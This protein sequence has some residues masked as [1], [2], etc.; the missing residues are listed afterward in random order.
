[1]G[2]ESVHAGIVAGQF[3]L[4]ERGM[5][6]LMADVVQQHRRPALSPFQLR[7][8]VMKALWNTRWDRAVAKGA[9]GIG[10]RH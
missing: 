9:D 5:N 1:M 10:H 4:G 7:D 2:S 6:F 8:Q 3:G